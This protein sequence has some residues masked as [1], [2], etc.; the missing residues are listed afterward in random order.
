MIRRV[1]AAAAAVLALSFLLTTPVAAQE[2]PAPTVQPD[3]VER[4]T[5]TTTTAPAVEVAGR[6][7][8]RGLPRTGGDIGGPAVIGLALTGAGIALAVGARR[9][10]KQ[11]ESA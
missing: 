10:R 5:T 9:R 1:I 8:T 7:V 3:V 2:S 6:T 11:L 4:T